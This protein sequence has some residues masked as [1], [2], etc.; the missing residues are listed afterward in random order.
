MSRGKKMIALLGV[1]IVLCVATFAVS[2]MDLNAEVVEETPSVSA[3]S[4]GSDAVV[5]ALSW[6]YNDETL[7]FCYA[8][9]TWSYA[10]DE[11]FPLDSTA[12]ESMISV[13]SDVTASRTL[14]DVEDLSEYGLDAPQAS[15]TVTTDDGTTTLDWGNESTLGDGRYLSIGD[16]NVYL[17]TDLLS[18]FT[19]ELYDLV[20]MESL[21]S[22]TQVT[23]FT[24]DAETQ[25]LSLVYLEESGLTYT[26]A[27]V[28][29]AADEEGYTALDTD[30]AESLIAEISAI[31]WVS[32]ENYNATDDD[33]AAYGLDS[34]TA[35]VTLNSPAPR[36]R[37][38]A[39]ARW[40]SKSAAII[41]T[42]TVTRAWAAAAWCIWWRRASPTTCFIPRPQTC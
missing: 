3:Y 38:R 2:R 18:Y 12:L 9:E 8:D 6:T 33:L 42:A 7:T 23:D 21:P 1:L 20:S 24:I 22:M 28:W 17:A 15:V 31:S 41:P 26:D 40:W 14:E 39:A 32:C 35:T 13:L 37:R 16:G 19:Y 36:M 11:S 29:F 10:D 5:S 27:L 4:I 34:P 30:L 25:T